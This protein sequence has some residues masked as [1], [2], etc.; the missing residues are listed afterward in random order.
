MFDDVF[1]CIHSDP[2]FI[3]LN[4]LIFCFLI[5]FLST[6]RCKIT[7][8]GDAFLSSLTNLVELDLSHNLLTAIPTDSFRSSPNW[9]RLVLSFNRFAVIPD[10]AFPENMITLQALDLSHCGIERMEDNAFVNLRTLKSLHLTG[11]KLKT[12]SGSTVEPLMDLQ[13]L[14]LHNNPWTCDCSL[15]DLRQNML[16][17][18]I[19]LSYPPTCADPKRL[20]GRDWSD[21]TLNDFACPPLPS[22]TMVSGDAHVNEGDDATLLCVAESI[23]LPDITWLRNGQVIVNGTLMSFGRQIYMIH[24]ENLSQHEKS[25]QLTIYNSMAKD[26]G[27]YQ[28]KASNN[29]GSF[30][31]NF[32][33]EIY[34]KTRNEFHEPSRHLDD[35]MIGYSGETIAGILFGSLSV[36]LILFLTVILVVVRFKN[37]NS[38]N[39]SPSSNL[40]ASCFSKCLLRNNDLHSRDH[41]HHHRREQE[42]PLDQRTTHDPQHY[43]NGKIGIIKNSTSPNNMTTSSSQRMREN[44]LMTASIGNS[45]S[46]YGS[47]D[48]ISMMTTSND[49]KSAEFA[50]QQDSLDSGHAGGS[51]ESG[52]S[53][54]TGLHSPS[55]QP[56]V[57]FVINSDSRC[58][59]DFV[60]ASGKKLLTLVKQ[61]HAPVKL[62][63]LR[64][65]MA[66]K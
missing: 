37:N 51:Y 4:S 38:L 8:V 45:G 3:P 39:P 28:C 57:N 19:P 43:M 58:S 22:A 1:R 18:G 52:T 31:M 17:R 21:L 34:L 63:Q 54:P 53:A 48:V 25:S 15:R 13:E 24:E 42:E 10:H 64:K 59:H 16:N 29:A 5:L 14:H 23:P 46:K 32:T 35:W 55:D 9:R 60:T 41:H 56:S 12:L 65:L 33:L 44:G 2:I 30:L 6:T 62:F 47:F 61:Q 7:W 36:L 49:H 27:V 40:S 11:N 26:E 66:R 20:Q 50:H